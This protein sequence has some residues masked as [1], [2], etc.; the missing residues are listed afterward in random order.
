[1]SSV[2]SRSVWLGLPLHFSP[3]SSLLL[4]LTE[5][6]G[7]PSV[8]CYRM[9]VGIL[10]AGGGRFLAPVPVMAV[11]ARRTRNQVACLN[12][13]STSSARFTTPRD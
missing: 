9:G 3:V 10:R 13:F 8:F 6:G 5:A 4:L 11:V 7:D 12:P 1:M 2:R